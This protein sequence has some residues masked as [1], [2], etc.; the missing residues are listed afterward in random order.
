MILSK[1]VRIGAFLVGGEWMTVHVEIK[2]E[3]RPEGLTLSIQADGRLPRRRE[4]ECGGQWMDGLREVLDRGTLDAGVSRA[5][6]ERLLTVWERWHLNHMRAGCEHQRAEKWDKRPLDQSKPTSA[7]IQH[8]DGQ[9]GWNMLTWVPVKDGGLL[10]AP[11][12]TCG[13]K[14]GSKWLYEPLPEEV[15]AFLQN[16]PGGVQ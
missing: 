15:V 1:R 3:E 12:P 2:T 5:S 13:Y 16:F 6:V 9:M 8:P 14:Y 11:C 7:Y 4:I 10:G